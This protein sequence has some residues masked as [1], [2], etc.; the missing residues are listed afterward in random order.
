[1]TSAEMVEL[2]RAQGKTEKPTKGMTEWTN[3]PVLAEAMGVVGFRV[4]YVA[5]PTNGTTRPYWRLNCNGNRFR[6]IIM[7][8][9]AAGREV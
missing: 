4:E 5:T 3:D 9:R 8:L 2:V 7:L 1:M 6:A